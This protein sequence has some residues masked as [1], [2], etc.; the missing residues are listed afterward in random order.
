VIASE[1]ITVRASS[2]TDNGRGICTSCSTVHPIAERAVSMEHLTGQV[3]HLGSGI[4]RILAERNVAQL[5]VHNLETAMLL[6]KATTTDEDT[7]L[8]AESALEILNGGGS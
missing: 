6:I 2:C 1:V 3:A 7:R 8:I 5:K 4:D